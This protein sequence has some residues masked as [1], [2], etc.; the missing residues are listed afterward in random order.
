[1]NATVKNKNAAER[2][3]L[4]KSLMQVAS[5]MLLTLLSVTLLALFSVWSL[6]QSYQR[7]TREVAELVSAL[8]TSRQAQVNFKRQVQDWKNILLRGDFPVARARYFNA[9]ESAEGDVYAALTQVDE[10]LVAAG[11][12]DY[13][14]RLMQMQLDHSVL[15]EK[16]RSAML[17]V[18]GGRWAPFESD[19][20]VRGIDRPLNKAID[21]L[22]AELLSESQTRSK[23]LNDAISTRYQALRYALWTTMLVSL[24][25]VGGMLWRIM[26]QSK[27]TA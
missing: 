26:V 10:I 25:L 5:V 1:M 8:D 16:Y 27:A 9:F 4:R 14:D 19:L 6:Q 20:A 7:N 3:D 24:L 17:D 11:E 12:R 23:V 13:H 18:S 22:A 15:G 21:N 2:A